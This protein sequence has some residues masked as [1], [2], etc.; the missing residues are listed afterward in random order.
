MGT[1]IVAGGI[2]LGFAWVAGLFWVAY[3]IV[4]W[5]DPNADARQRWARA[6]IG[7]TWLAAALFLVLGAFGAFSRLGV[8]SAVGLG[9]AVSLRNPSAASARLRTDLERLSA[10]IERLVGPRPWRSP[11]R[12][13]A[14]VVA[15]VQAVRIV[16]ELLKPPTATDALTYHL[17]RAGRFVQR[18]AWVIEPTPD[19]GFYYAYYPPLGDAYWAWTLLWTHS[20]AL[21]AVTLAGVLV[22]IVV[23]FYLAARELD[24]QPWSA[25]WGGL[26]IVATP[27][28]GSWSSAAYVDGM[29]L[30]VFLLAVATLRPA[31]ERPSPATVVWP[32]AALALGLGI[33]T[34]GVVPLGLG[35]LILGIAVVGRSLRPVPTFVAGILACAVVL[36]VLWLGGARFGNP[37]YPFGLPAL[38][39][40]PNAELAALQRGEFLPAPMRHFEWFTFLRILFIPHPGSRVAHLNF[41]PAVLL[42]IPFV[43]GA[44]HWWQGPKRGLACLFVATSL[45]FIAQLASEDSLGIR[46]EAAPSIGRYLTIPLAIVVLAACATAQGAPRA[47]TLVFAL[48]IAVGA[49]LSVPRGLGPADVQ[50]AWVGVPVL[51]LGRWVVRLAFVAVRRGWWSAHMGALAALLTVIAGLTI[52]TAY[53]PRF[54]A[55][56]LEQ[57]HHNHIFDPHPTDPKATAAW[58]IW[59]WLEHQPPM[60]IAFAAGWDT[61][62]AHWYR[63]PLLGSRLKHEVVYVANTHDGE[64]IDYR[65]DAELRARASYERWLARLVADEIDLVILGVPQSVEHAWVL[66]HPDRFVPV[67]VGE[68]RFVI[69]FRFR[70]GGD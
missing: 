49:Y 65:L 53:R 28:V 63:A 8:S 47:V 26:A 67:L 55:A 43:A 4:D 61:V 12:I 37:L 58:P 56:Y 66:A 1:V 29:L 36:P 32:M 35:T 27:A 68:G 6:L 42:L 5:V 11:L 33:K 50:A 40:A 24:I 25:A 30:A 16:R 34:P 7:G 17:F 46:T 60:R 59:V 23:G 19:A 3:R 31:L 18:G 44:R 70:R 48:V 14:L 10:M 69:A 41:G 21:V 62:G 54:R 2:V 51:L 57:L 52:T 38:G 9:V 22:A 64:L 20:D 13:A 15:S 39:W 45:V